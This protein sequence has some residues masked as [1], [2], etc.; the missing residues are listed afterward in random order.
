MNFSNNLAYIVCQIH[1]RPIV[2]GIYGMKNFDTSESEVNIILNY[3]AKVVNEYN[4][5]TIIESLFV[6]VLSQ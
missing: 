4:I 2:R 3:T 6:K 1:R 5:I